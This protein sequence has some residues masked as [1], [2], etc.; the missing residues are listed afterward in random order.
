MVVGPT[1]EVTLA[2]SDGV[3]HHPDIAPALEGLQP[4][5]R[6]VW[7]RATDVRPLIAATAITR[8]WDVAAV[9]RL[10]AG[11]SRDDAA[12]A[13]ATV[14][15]LEPPSPDERPGSGQDD[16][17][18]SMDRTD[19]P[20]RD[21]EQLPADVASPRRLADPAHRAAYARA[22]LTVALRQA[23]ILWDRVGGQACAISE[24][25][26][27]LLAVELEQ[28]GLPVDR[29]V[30]EQLIE[31]SAGP[32][33]Q[34]EEEAVANRRQRDEL[35]WRHSPGGRPFDLRNPAAVKEALR[36]SG[37]V[38]E[39]TRAWH[40]EPYRAG[41]PFVD[42]LLTWRKAERIATTYGWHWTDTSIGTDDRLRGGWD[43][44]DGGAGRMTAGSGLHSLPTPLR[45]GIVAE[46]GHLFVR[47]DLGQIEPRVL[48]VV[49]RDPQL[50]Q[51]THAD[52]LYASIATELDVD[53]PTAKI[54]MLAAMYG[55]TSGMAGQVVER[56]ERS[57]PVSMAYLR[58]AAAEGEGG[59]AVTTYGGRLVPV[60]SDP[61]GEVWAAR[62]RGR[63]TRNAVVQGAAAEL[64]KAW[65][66][67]VRAGV[68]PLG[69][70]I[71][72]CLHDELLVHTPQ[73]QADAVASAVDQSLA[74]A[75]R[76]WSQGAP[77]RFVTDT[78]V[79][80]SW[81]EAKG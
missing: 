56:F 29:P 18:F 71:V 34:S 10:V 6:L 5:T 64:F 74:D 73:D 42:A 79:M 65:A 25:G 51:A 80:R 72:L 49:A 69:A 44:S 9:H 36:S 48:A 45:P 2:D 21:G 37:V 67:T 50:A 1:G 14:F 75:A 11:G 78:R 38:V 41:S 54:A 81:S 68:R 12:T 61:S 40:L 22:A 53:R 8:C 59:R 52:D 20:I 3:V 30:L 17:L 57:Y 33:P 16:D 28:Q 66:L 46:P 27:A 47:A 43:P 76:R 7:W 31:Q 62:A 32:R 26:A 15:G 19:L 23:Q 63:F 39:D 4:A 35:V 58:D 13:W 60:G 55:Q 70:R 24:S 77:V